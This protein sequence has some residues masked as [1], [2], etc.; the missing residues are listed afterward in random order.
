MNARS[1][2]RAYHLTT[3]PMRKLSVNEVTE[4]LT[5]QGVSASPQCGRMLTDTAYYLPKRSWFVGSFAKTLQRFLSQLRLHR[6]VEDKNDCD[7]SGQLGSFVGKLIHALDDQTKDGGVAIG[8]WWY[9]RDLDGGMH[10]VP[11]AITTDE[12]GKLELAFLEI[13]H[14]TELKLSEGEVHSCMGYRL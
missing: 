14:F 6:W 1:G 11:F 7:D 5:S 2:D 8:E 13:L 10:S 9:V 12:A 3:T 4:F